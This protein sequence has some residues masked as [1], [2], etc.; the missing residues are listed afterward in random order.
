MIFLILLIFTGCPSLVTGDDTPSD[1]DGR[2]RLTH[3]AEPVVSELT[4]RYFGYPQNSA[5]EDRNNFLEGDFRATFNGRLGERLQYLVV[6]QVRF[7]SADKTAFDAEFLEDSLQ[8]PAFT[9]H[10]AYAA[11][12]GDVYEIAAG[13]KI[14]TWGVGDGYKP[15]DNINPSDSLDVPTAE[16]I[17]VP[18]L[19]LYRYG[20]TVNVDFVFVP[21]FTPSRVPEKID[22]RWAVLDTSG[23]DRV[24]QIYGQYPTVVDAGRDLPSKSLE[25]AQ[26][27]LKLGSSTLLTGWDLA[28]SYYRGFYPIGV[29]ESRV[30]PPGLSGGVMTPP[31]LIVKK[32]YP[33][34]QEFG[35]SFSTASG[36]WE[37]HGEAAFHLTDD[38][39]M[40]IDYWEY[41]AG[42]NYTFPETFTDHLEKI[43]ATVEYAGLSVTRDRPEDSRFSDAGFGRGLTNSV[44]GRVTFKFSEDTQFEV[45]GAYNF[46]DGDYT[47]E[48]VLMHK[49]FDRITVETG[50]QLFE[51]PEGSFFGEWNDNDR[52]FIIGTCHF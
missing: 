12:Y 17:G 30:I 8:R 23:L 15:T 16:K 34:C 4:L 20:E 19:S 7:D 42:F 24:N 46:D 11:W 45:A 33:K 43:M 50:Y 18:A 35:G 40:D 38:E 10:E 49:A 48:A 47:A 21:F 44:L 1:A 2:G 39:E 25:N 32:M 5:L 37:F 9:V 41:I 52:L 28:A 13:K 6:P 22:N 27:A 3:H 31:R 29:L 51:G 14:F 36:D 26:Y